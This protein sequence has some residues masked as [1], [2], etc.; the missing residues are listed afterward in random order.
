MLSAASGAALVFLACTGAGASVLALLRLIRRLDPAERLA[1]S[2]AIGIGVLGWTL[3]FPGVA[4]WFGAGTIGAVCTAAAL[5]NLLLFRPRPVPSA[6]ARAAP[7]GTVTWALLATMALVAG[8]DLIEALAPPADADSVAYHFALPK[9]FLAD[10]RI[11]F[12]PRAATGAAPLLL[13]MTYAAALEFGGETGLTLWTMAS[14]W[15]AALML[16]VVARRHLARDWALAVAL[17]F[18][19]TPALAAGAGTGQVETRIALFALAGAVAVW[20]SGRLPPLRAALLAGLLA[21]FYAGAKFMGLLFAAVAGLVLLLRPR[22]VAR[23]VVFGLG[24]GLAGFQW[25]L[26]SWI[27]TGDPTFPVLFHLFGLPDS[28]L[29]TQAHDAWYRRQY[30]GVE[31]PLAINALNFLAYPFL[32]SFGIPAAIE[33]GRTGFGPYGLLVLPFALAGLWQARRRM[34]QSA[35]FPAALV[36]ALF[37]LFWFVSGTSQRLRHLLP[38]WPILLLCLSVAATRWAGG[39]VRRPLAAAAALV[40][41]VQL[42][43]MAVFTANMARLVFG[44][45]DHVDYLRRNIGLYR[46][47]EWLN[48]HIGTGE[49]VLV[50]ENEIIYHLTVP[51]YFAHWSAQAMVEL[52]P[53][54]DD[55]RRFLAQTAALGITHVLVPFG[56]DAN[57]GRIATH[58][59]SGGFLFLM[60]RLQRADC[61]VPLAVFNAPRIASRTL[62]ALAVKPPT[63]ARAAVMALKRTGCAP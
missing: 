8:F 26:W 32:A 11:T 13:H 50:T 53:Q 25:Y 7:A 58:G 43:G 17:I 45:E 60:D 34:A 1:W 30:F 41:L 55:P 56:Y 57:S 63:L 52:T 3:F 21:G 15:M 9:Q 19:T 44:A 4:G 38:L 27:H 16:Y 51:H 22:R 10:G 48:R 46:A 31:T 39:P 40:I 37:Y 24:L 54:S 62:S 18:A 12:V 5:G 49:R 33:A 28:P 47:V 59:R 35:L 20:D 61:L 29:W 14:G 2:F 6:P 42:G 36:A 23:A